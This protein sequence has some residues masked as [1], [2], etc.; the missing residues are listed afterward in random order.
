MFVFFSFL[1]KNGYNIYLISIQLTRSWAAH[2]QLGLKNRK[3]RRNRALHCL[4]PQM[5]KSINSEKLN[6][7]NIDN[8]KTLKKRHL[9]L[10]HP[11]RYIFIF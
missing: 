5:I 3:N 4:Q 8:Y 10:I 9:E 1:F 11:S 6:E 7:L 2:E